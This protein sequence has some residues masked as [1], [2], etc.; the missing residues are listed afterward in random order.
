[1]RSCSIAYAI[2]ETE[3]ARDTVVK[4]V[5][6]TGGMCFRNFAITMHEA[7]HEPQAVI[8]SNFKDQHV[9][10]KVFRCFLGVLAIFFALCLW[11]LVFYLPYAYYAMSFNY[12][13]G[14]WP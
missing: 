11:T 12:G 13:Q 3:E 7:Q 2:F 5:V 4:K 10:W 8:W 9:L 1:M 14:Q 6:K